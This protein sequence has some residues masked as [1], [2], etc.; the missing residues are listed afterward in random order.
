MV[1]GGLELFLSLK[2][3]REKQNKNTGKG[4]NKLEKE[5]GRL[6]V[7]KG[8]F[9]P[10]KRD[11]TAPKCVGILRDGVGGGVCKR[12]KP[13]KFLTFISTEK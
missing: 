10:L 12:L 1:T 9:P 13:V 3:E 4:E 5:R 7:Q 6:R 2:E 11:V 8:F